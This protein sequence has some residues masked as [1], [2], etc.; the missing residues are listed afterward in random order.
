MADAFIQ[1][2]ANSKNFTLA[3]QNHDLQSFTSD[4]CKGNYV[5]FHIQS[6]TPTNNVQVLF[7]MTVDGQAWNGQ[8]AGQGDGWDVSLKLLKGIKLNPAPGRGS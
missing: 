4:H 1:Q 7:L 2:A 3:D 8:Y 6:A 5:V